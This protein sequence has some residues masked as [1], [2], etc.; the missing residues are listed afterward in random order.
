MLDEFDTEAYRTGM[1]KHLNFDV[2]RMRTDSLEKCVELLHPKPD[3]DESLLVFRILHICDSSLWP[4]LELRVSV[5]RDKLAVLKKCLYRAAIVLDDLHPVVRHELFA[6]EH[7]EPDQIKAKR[8][9]AIT[10]PEILGTL[11]ERCAPEILHAL[12]AEC[13]HIEERYPRR[14]LG[15]KPKSQRNWL[16]RG[17]LFLFEERRPGD[18]R[19]TAGEF[20][21]FAQYLNQFCNGGE[22]EDLKNS[23]D[24]AFE[25]FPRE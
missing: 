11:A 6:L 20:P 2:L 5:V 12:A 19:P 24:F 14:K 7:V 4:H 17:G 10:H 23:M 13:A 25:S 21:N 3:E 1:F 8:W 9:K 15:R 16:I 22:K 18:A